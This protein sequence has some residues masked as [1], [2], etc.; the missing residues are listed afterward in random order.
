M[1]KKDSK[2][3]LDKMSAVN[4]FLDL[5]RNTAIQKMNENK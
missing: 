4:Q 1:E 2:K 5:C 3:A